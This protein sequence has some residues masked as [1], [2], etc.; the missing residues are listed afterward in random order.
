VGG[1]WSWVGQTL[2]L[3]LWLAYLAVCYRGL[4][5][6]TPEGR[7]QG[8][9]GSHLL[10]TLSLVACAWPLATAGL[11]AQVG[12]QWLVAV[13]AGRR[14]TLEFF[15]WCLAQVRL[16][17]GDAALPPAAI[18][19][20][21]VGNA[22]WAWISLRLAARAWR[23]RRP[24]AAQALGLGAL[25]A[26]TAPVA[27]C[28]LMVLSI[29]TRDR[30]APGIPRYDAWHVWTHAARAALG[31]SFTGEVVPAWLS[32][33]AGT[34]LITMPVA[35][36]GACFIGLRGALHAHPDHAEGRELTTAQP[37]ARLEVVPTAQGA[38]AEP[39]RRVNLA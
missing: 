32:L 5:A 14:C 22:L 7:A 3:A 2:W 27:L 20:A 13:L 39:E 24:R 15:G 21:F 34:L 26:A 10:A 37:V 19:A 30:A 12:A 31:A 29:I 6:L 23:E 4:L 1:P 17:H 11:V 28:A 18:A 36:A 35:V 33:L 38:A 9:T 8:G 16:P 25:H